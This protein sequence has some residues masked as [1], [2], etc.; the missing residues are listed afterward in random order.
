M[1]VN[2]TFLKYDLEEKVYMKQSEGF[3]SRSGEHIVCKVN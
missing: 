3:L 1:D 2:T